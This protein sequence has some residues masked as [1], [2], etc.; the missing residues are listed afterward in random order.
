VEDLRGTP[1]VRLPEIFLSSSLVVCV[2]GLLMHIAKAT[3]LPAIVIYGGREHPA[4][5]G[6]PGQIHLSSG[7]LPCR[8]RWG[9]HLGPDLHCAHGMKCMEQ[10]SPELVGGQALEALGIHAKKLNP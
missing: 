1:V 5:D 3:G 4:I 6:Y 10:I 9:C 2:V 7:P 8:G